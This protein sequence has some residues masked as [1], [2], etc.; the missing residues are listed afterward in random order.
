[1][2]RRECIRSNWRVLIT[3]AAVAGVTLSLGAQGD[4]ATDLKYAV[5]ALQANRP[6]AALAGLRPLAKSLPRIGDYV[7]WFTA[8]AEFNLENYTSVPQL[9]EPVWTQSPPSPLAGRA[10]MLGSQAY[11]MS[12]DAPDSLNLLRKYYTA[13]AQPAG[14]LAMAKAFA[15]NGDPVSAA[16]YAQRVYYG[17][18][19]A[20]EAVEA[21]TL[22]ANLRAQLSERYPPAM[23]D[24][25]LGRALKL[26]DAGE[27][28]KARA[29]LS[30]LLSPLGGADHDVAQVK[31]GV[32][33]YLAKDA[34]GAQ[35]YL[36]DLVVAA[37]AA[38]AERLQY[39]L[40]RAPRR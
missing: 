40:L 14:D 9:L 37:P 11:Q 10:A 24:A 1:M 33:Q 32:A 36:K 39:L 19:S 13:L 17:Y 20:N 22:A 18:P 4:P 21:G 15:A 26:L 5:A 8:T 3:A 34:A 30:D 2:F 25:M 6:A 35:R 29:E 7:A 23:G 28:S 27:F 16:I 38:D 12:G 31:L